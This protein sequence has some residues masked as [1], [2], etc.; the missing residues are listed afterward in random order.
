MIKTIYFD[1]LYFCI[2]ILQLSFDFFQYPVNVASSNISEKFLIDRNRIFVDI[3]RE[4]AQNYY[5]SF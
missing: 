3:A 2:F 1:M 4:N 5:F